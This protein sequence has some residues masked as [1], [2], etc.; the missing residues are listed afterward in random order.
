MAGVSQLEKRRAAGKDTNVSR[1]FRPDYIFDIIFQDMKKDIL[2]LL[3]NHRIACETRN[4]IINS[5]ASHKASH[6]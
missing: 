3:E 5:F 2:G 1:Y 4:T 6:V